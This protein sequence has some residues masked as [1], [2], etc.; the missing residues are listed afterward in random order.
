[1]VDELRRQY[2]FRLGAN[3]L[4]TWDVH[5][6]LALA[7]D[8]PVIEVPLSTI[9]ELDEPYWFQDGMTPTCRDVVEHVRLINAA[10]LRFPIILSSDGRVMDG[11]HRVAKALMQAAKTVL[12]RQFAHDPKPDHV[13]IE[14]DRLPY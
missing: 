7:E 3:G 12:A 11:M 4:Q 1:M 13:G 10:D 9:R 8:L 6:L 2:H 14:P 5:R